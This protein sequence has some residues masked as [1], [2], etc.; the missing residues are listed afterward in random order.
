MI[1]SQ[2]LIR[3]LH[4]RGSIPFGLGVVAG[5]D[6]NCSIVLRTS[7]YEPNTSVKTEVLACVIAIE[8]LLNFKLKIVRP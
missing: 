4:R 6:A 3:A 2:A 8:Y 1:V 7:T 5:A